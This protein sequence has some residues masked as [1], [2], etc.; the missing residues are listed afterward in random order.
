MI[1]VESTDPVAASGTTTPASE[2]E[3]SLPNPSVEFH[4]KESL[5]F[6]IWLTICS[7]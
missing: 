2:P 3:V 4:K 7:V 6:F 5:D 1:V